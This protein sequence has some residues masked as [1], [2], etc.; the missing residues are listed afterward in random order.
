MAE[1]ATQVDPR[2][3]NTNVW[4]GPKQGD[5]D[6]ALAAAE[7]RVTA[8]YR[9]QI[10]THSALEPH[11]STAEP[12]GQGGLTVWC[13]TQGTFSVRRDLAGLTKLPE[14]QVRV[15]TEYMGGGFGAKFGADVCD[16][17][18]AHFALGL[19][20]PVRCMNDRREEHLVG[21]NRP[22]SIQRLTLGGQEGRH[23][24]RDRRRD[25]RHRGHVQR[26]RHG[27]RQHA[28]STASRT[29]ASPR[30]RSRRTRRSARAFRAPGH[31]QGVF[32]LEGMVDEYAH[33]IGMDPLD[34]RRLNDQHPIRRLEWPIGAKQIDWAANRRK[35]P[36]SDPGPVKRGVGCAGGVW[37]N[38]GGG[39]HRVDV[40]VGQGRQRH[41]AQR[42][43][44]HRHGHQDRARDRR[45]RGARHPAVGGHRAHR[46]HDASRPA[47]AAAAA[48]RRCRSR[49]PRA[50]PP[51]GPARGWRPRWPLRGAPGPRPSASRAA[52]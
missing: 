12:D 23:P 48:S 50:R 36:G 25:V 27:L 15:L 5:V 47:P 46:R 3:P 40:T 21:G 11:G 10:Q 24:H 45:G 44:G 8:E 2:K 14:A 16:R 51:C 31:P 32:A 41:R 19:K 35:V 17:V 9:T 43:A 28:G 38:F 18:A 39:D 1:G 22:D 52:R 26:R 7:A 42:R 33:A 34:V 30:R 29:S 20:R 6:A 49:P 4:G 37:G 13:S